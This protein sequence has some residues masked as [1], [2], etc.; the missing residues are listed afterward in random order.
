MQMYLVRNDEI[1]MFNHVFFKNVF[2]LKIDKKLFQI[3]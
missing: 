3:R 1:N 2:N